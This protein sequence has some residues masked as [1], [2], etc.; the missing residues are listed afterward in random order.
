MG[1]QS[2]TDSSA[3]ERNRTSRDLG[4]APPDQKPTLPPRTSERDPTHAAHLSFRLKV[5]HRLQSGAIYTYGGTGIF[6]VVAA[7]SRWHLSSQPS[8]PA[9]RRPSR[10][11]S[12]MVCISRAASGRPSSFHCSRGCDDLFEPPPFLHRGSMSR[13]ARRSSSSAGAFFSFSY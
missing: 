13:Q 6:S 12:S 8:M 11:M 7:K 5:C 2:G 9:P 4:A 3:N 1:L 10:R